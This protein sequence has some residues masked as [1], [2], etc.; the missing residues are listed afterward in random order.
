VLTTVLFAAVLFFAGVSSKFVGMRTRT[1]TVAFAVVLLLSGAA[2]L[3][4][5]PVEI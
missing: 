2:I 3:A 5:F 1:L 4:T